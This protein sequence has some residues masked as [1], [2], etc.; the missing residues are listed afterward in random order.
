M[1]K[2]RLTNLVD[3]E[4][5]GIYTTKANAIE[6]MNDL[7]DGINET[8]GETVENGL[9]QFDFKLDTIEDADDEIDSFKWAIKHLSDK[10]AYD[11]SNK[12][13]LSTL[14]REAN[15]HHT[16]A[17][18]ALNRLFTIAEAWND[19][20]GFVPD[21]SN[22]KQNKWFPFFSYNKTYGCF[23]CS[24]IRLVNADMS[25]SIG[26]RLCFAT[27][28]IAEQFGKRFINLYN[29]VFSLNNAK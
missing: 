9:S 29:Q 8:N 18:I 11:S 24:S 22:E 21:F 17:L 27:E 26:A 28:D 20:C 23:M 10:C 12:E 5:V 14:T 25:A 19:K 15:P 7:V 1:K 2:Y 3:N 6:V 16:K 13:D 4:V